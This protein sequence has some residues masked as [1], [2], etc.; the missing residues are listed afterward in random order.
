MLKKWGFLKNL[1]QKLKFLTVF[2][3]NELIFPKT[4]IN[5][6]PPA[7]E[8]LKNIYRCMVFKKLFDILGH[9]IGTGAWVLL[10]Y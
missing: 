8:F 7:A 1:Q 10:R 5:S 2:V 9:T 3:R 4:P 6:P